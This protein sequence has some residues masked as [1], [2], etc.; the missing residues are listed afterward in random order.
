M[1]GIEEKRFE[2][3]PSIWARRSDRS[4]AILNSKK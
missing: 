3:T 1:W 4:L 2:E